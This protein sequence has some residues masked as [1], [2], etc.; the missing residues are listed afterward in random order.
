MRKGEASEVGDGRKTAEQDHP[1]E[2]QRMVGE[3]G[4]MDGW[5]GFWKSCSEVCGCEL[6]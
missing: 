1:G 4:R 2:R 3:C 6:R 5:T